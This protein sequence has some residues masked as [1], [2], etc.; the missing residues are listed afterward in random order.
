MSTNYHLGLVVFAGS[1]GAIAFSSIFG[2]A[3]ASAARFDR[4]AK[5]AAKLCDR[6]FKLA[7]STARDQVIEKHGSQ[8]AGR[9]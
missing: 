5:N 3:S 4:Y 1:I 9:P 6:K 2:I 7:C 8:R